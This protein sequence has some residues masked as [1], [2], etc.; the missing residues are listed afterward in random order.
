MNGRISNEAKAKKILADNLR[1]L[2]RRSESGETLTEAQLRFVEFVAKGR[3]TE[4]PSSGFAKNASE[5][6]EKLNT[7][8]QLISHHA[9]NPES[10]GRTEDGRYD[11]AK[12]SEFLIATGRKF[13]ADDRSER[14]TKRLAA[15]HEA[16][17]EFAEMAFWKVS[18]A[19]PRSV[20]FVLESAELEVTDKKRD[21]ITHL[22]WWFLAS[23]FD[24]FL[25]EM[26]W[27]EFFEEPIELPQEIETV[28]RRLAGE[29]PCNS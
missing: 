25:R 19:L 16:K 27:N 15:L 14:A 29:E 11:V 23:V 22:L 1:N 28:R 17:A 5:L 13:D 21:E 24:G 8:R 2:R 26:G 4:K 10:P 20:Q 9:K 18:N 3:H 7:S 6:A 12:W